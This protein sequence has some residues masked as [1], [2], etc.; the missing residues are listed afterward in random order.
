MCIAMVIE[1][2]SLITSEGFPDTLFCFF[3]FPPG[4]ASVALKFS[5]SRI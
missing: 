3:F 2:H 1:D 4:F 5:I